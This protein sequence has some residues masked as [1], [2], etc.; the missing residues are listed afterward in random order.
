MNTQ[1][2][3]FLV[4]GLVSLMFLFVFSNHIRAD[5][6]NEVI[7]NGHHVRLAFK[8]TVRVGENEF[9]LQLTDAHSQPVIIDTHLE[10]GIAPDSNAEKKAKQTT[11]S[12]QSIEVVLTPIGTAGEYAGIVPLGTSGHWILTVHFSV[13]GE[14]Y[15]VNFPVQVI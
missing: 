3:K 15:E 7:V 2:S 6:G 8:D 12:A 11:Q 10:V 4:R 9:N 14:L 5:N 1:I 13:Q